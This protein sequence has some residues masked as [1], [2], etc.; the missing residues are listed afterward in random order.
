[1][2]DFTQGTQARGW[3]FKSPE[4]LSAL[5]LVRED[6]T[7]RQ[8]PTLACPL[9]PLTH[10]HT[11]LTGELRARAQALAKEGMLQGA[12]VRRFA[13]AASTPRLNHFPTPPHTKQPTPRSFASRLSGGSSSSGK[14]SATQAAGVKRPLPAEQPLPQSAELE[15]VTAADEATLLRYF[16]YMIQDACGHKSESIKRGPHVA[17]TAMAYFRRFFLSNSMLDFDPKV[18][19]MACIFL[20]GKIEYEYIRLGELRDVFGDKYGRAIIDFEGPL[21][22]GLGFHLKLFH[23]YNPFFGLV[24]GLECVGR[25]N[26]CLGG[27]N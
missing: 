13:D 21:L 15:A 3:L 16:C 23:P 17:A 5:G 10:T 26:M 24:N 11:R 19:L 27:V 14:P 12:E 8:D 2:F 25:L 4:E 22:Q 18:A 1:M 7:T 6:D 9:D 20:A